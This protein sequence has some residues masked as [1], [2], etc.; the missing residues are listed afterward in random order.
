MHIEFL[1][2]EP[3]MEAA[4]VRLVPKIL[5]DRATFKVHNFGDK[6]TLLANLEA[7]LRGYARWL[8]TD[9][10]IVVLVDRD[11]DDCRRLKARLEKA[12]KAAGLPTWTQAPARDRVR[13]VNRIVI[14]ELE[15]WFFGDAVAIATAFPRVPPTLASRRGYADPDAIR[16]GT[17]EALQRELRRA[18]YFRAGMPKINTAR[19]IAAHMDPDRNRSRS[20]RLFRD[21]LR[22]LLPHPPPAGPAGTGAA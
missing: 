17:W 2:E 13:V 8:P 12:A 21:T 19:W 11:A 6:P 3:S 22:S 1:V 7:R 20:F 15:A 9:W 18:G 5:G 4:L 16:G 14:E 10:R